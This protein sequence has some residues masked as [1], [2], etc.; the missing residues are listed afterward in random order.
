[1]LSE[2]GGA[3]PFIAQVL[4]MFSMRSAVF[5][6]TVSS[7]HWLRP[8]HFNLIPTRQKPLQK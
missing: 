1:M 7:F 3:F 8:L 6:T 5:H 4:D 2:V